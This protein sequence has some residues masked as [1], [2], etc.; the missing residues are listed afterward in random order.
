MFTCNN[1]SRQIVRLMKKTNNKS[2]NVLIVEDSFFF[3]RWLYAEFF[4]IEGLEIV[5]YANNY[6]D[7]S[8]M[9]ENLV[10]DI[11]IIDIK[12]KEGYGTNLI[13]GIKSKNENIVIIVFSNFVECKEECLKLGADYFFDKSHEFDDLLNLLSFLN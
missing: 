13:K 12:L 5:G 7:A 10:V 9:I 6:K 2:T 4:K 11:A 3:S 1:N 8:L